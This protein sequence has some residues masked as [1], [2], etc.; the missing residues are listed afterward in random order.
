ME[1]YCPSDGP[2][3]WV[4]P[5]FPV[6]S[7][8]PYLVGEDWVSI[9]VRDSGVYQ[10]EAFPPYSVTISLVA[11]LINNDRVVVDDLSLKLNGEP[12]SG[13]LLRRYGA[14]EYLEMP[15]EF[16]L[17]TP[18][19]NSRIAFTTND[20]DIAHESGDVLSVA[21]TIGVGR[22]ETEHRR[23]ISRDFVARIH[24]GVF[25]VDGFVGRPC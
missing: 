21:V 17:S 2:I 22:T 25:R 11:G 24:R 20:I 23:T 14:K 7:H 16:S 1:V 5:P 13:V 3:R 6:A 9:V 18:K 15:A 19:N 8:G 12:L 4:D 10:G